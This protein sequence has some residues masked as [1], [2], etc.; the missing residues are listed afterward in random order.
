MSGGNPEKVGVVVT[1][2][3]SFKDRVGSATEEVGESVEYLD[4]TRFKNSSKLE[5]STLVSETEGIRREILV[6]ASNSLPFS[7]LS[8]VP[9]LLSGANRYSSTLELNLMLVS[10]PKS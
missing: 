10:E 9:F 3:A 6:V 5:I 4:S 8:S 1:I 7:I 2:S